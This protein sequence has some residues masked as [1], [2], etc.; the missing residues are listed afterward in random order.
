[1][2]DFGFYTMSHPEYFETLS[3]APT[4]PDYMQELHPLLPPHWK[5]G[6]TDIWLHA[7]SNEAPLP[8]EGFKIHLSCSPSDAI[9][10]IKRFVPICTG[11]DVQFKIAADPML[12]TYLN[13]KR[14]ARG[15]SGKFATIY[16]PNHG[17]FLVLI[18]KLHE[19]TKDLTG[20][21]ILSDKRYPGSK[22]VFY[23]WG[24]F[25][26]IRNLRPDGI[27]RLM[28]H[29]PDGSLTFD[30]RTPYFQL[31]AWVQDPFPGEVDEGDE[32]ALLHGRYKVEKP[33]AFSN[34]GGVYCAEDQLTGLKV[35]IKEARPGTVVWGPRKICIDSTTILQ[36]EYATLEHLRGL[37][38]VPQ[39]IEFYEEWEH[40]FLVQTFFDGIPMANFRALE[41]TAVISKMDDLLAII[42]FCHKWREICIRLLDAVEAIHAR[43]VII[44]DISPGNVLI[45]PETRELRL[46]DFEGALRSNASKEIKDIGTQWFNPGFRKLER[47][48]AAALSRVD[49][50]YACGMLLYNLVCPIQSLFELDRNQPVFRILDHF[51]EGGLPQ[52]IREIIALL[53][54]GDSGKAR[55]IA[56]SWQLPAF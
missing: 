7:G 15:S 22:V 17:T 32:N 18:P 24:G 31:P 40:T 26:R 36:N 50:F 34:T 33:L 39:A 54:E 48:Q 2:D 5:A 55:T 6:R 19:A 21:Y 53:L 44:G 29:A 8:A 46:I 13:S 52:Q 9:T 47:R 49:D 16:P 3:R 30:D 27:Q 10:M 37:A 43:H 12:H 4:Q 45:K 14:C 28:V 51:V 56:K 41:E 11:M 20:P 1:M 25:Q 35:V 38:C 23:R 42:G